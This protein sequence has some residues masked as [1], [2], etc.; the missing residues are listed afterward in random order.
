MAEKVLRG[1]DKLEKALEKIS[2]GM[3]GELSVGFMSGAT[4]PDGTPVSA[5]AFWN[6]FG[7]PGHNQPARPFFRGM[8][9]KESPSWP[10]EIAEAARTTNYDGK[11]VLELMG[12]EIAGKLTESINDFSG[13][14][15]SPSTVAK[16]GFDKQLVDTGLMVKSVTFKVKE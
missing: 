9:E 13:A 2:A 4:Y 8:I 15:L 3:H 16:K 7:V 11:K 14:P 12:Q 6:E 5:V 10:K 1:G